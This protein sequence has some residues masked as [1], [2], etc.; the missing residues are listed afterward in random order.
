MRQ[1]I[2]WASYLS[3]PCLFACL[4]ILAR[5]QG[6]RRWVAFA[7]VVAASIMAYARFVEPRLLWTEHTD[8]TLKDAQPNGPTIRL[9]LFSDT[10][11]GIFKQAMSMQ[12]IVER[13]NREAPDAVMIAGD[14]LYYLPARDIPAALAPLAD[15]HAPVFAVLGNHDVGF[16][17]PIYTEELYAALTA[18]GVTLVENRAYPTTLAGHEVIVAGTSDLWQ[19]QHDFGFSTDLP[20]LPTFWLAH[21]PDTAF[22]APPSTDYDLMLAG[23]THGGQIRIPGLFR[24]VIPTE[25]PF[26]KG[27]HTVRVGNQDRFVYVTPGTGM[28]GLP[29]RLNMPPRIDIL[30]VTIPT[31]PSVTETQ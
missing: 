31:P 29:F 27:L 16:P 24:W 14:F 11:F 3:I 17:G 5:Q 1:L 6:A 13:V 18:L 22:E 30:T 7:V 28:V 12:R 10:H 23:H 4:I 8:I 21:N 26:D 25:H 9:A 20:D 15:L 2:F 19:Q